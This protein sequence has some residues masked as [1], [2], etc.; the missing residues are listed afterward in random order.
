MPD[1]SASALEFVAIWGRVWVARI[2]GGIFLF[3]AAG[4]GLIAL[5]GRDLNAG[6]IGL[7]T[8]LS[9]PMWAFGLWMLYFASNF[10]RLRAAVKDAGLQVVGLTGTRVWPFRA[11]PRDRKSTRL[12]S[13][14]LKLSRMPSS[15]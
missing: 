13:S 4:M 1:S 12:N 11:V 8:I 15:A 7:L 5:L 10:A 14:H 2:A 9:L 3:F 6:A